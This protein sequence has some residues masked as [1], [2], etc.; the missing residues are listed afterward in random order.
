MTSKGTR[1]KQTAPMCCVFCVLAPF[2]AYSR[3]RVGKLCASGLPPWASQGVSGC[4]FR[5]FH[6]IL[7]L[8]KTRHGYAK[9]ELSSNGL[10]FYSSNN[11]SN[12]RHRISVLIA[13]VDF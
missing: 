10:I 6:R 1:E 8:S 9:K 12:E 2:V 5:S 13:K 7:I 3:D 11:V 4:S